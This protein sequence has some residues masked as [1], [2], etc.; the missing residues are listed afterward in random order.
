M[1]FNQNTLR[2]IA[3]GGHMPDQEY[4][5]EMAKALMKEV[6]IVPRLDGDKRPDGSPQWY[7]CYK[8]GVKRAEIYHA[9]TIKSFSMEIDG[10]NKDWMSLKSLSECEAELKR[11]LK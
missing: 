8:E 3:E 11:I 6:F 7:D 10:N 9:S 2:I 5:I 4:V 1:K